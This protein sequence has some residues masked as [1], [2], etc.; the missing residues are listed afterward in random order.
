MKQK[1]P[2]SFQQVSMLSFNY[3]ILLGC[4]TTTPLIFYAFI[5]EKLF[6]I[7][8]Y[9]IWSIICSYSLH[10]AWNWVSIKCK[11]G[12]IRVI[13]SV[14][15][16]IKWVQVTLVKSST[17]VRNTVWPVYV[18]VFVGTP[19]IYMEQLES[20]ANVDLMVLIGKDFLGCF[21][22]GHIWQICFAKHPWT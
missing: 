4:A 16:F 1:R 8:F 13:E 9:K 14:L 5:K 6:H 19:N 3:P 11:K 17:M 15:F 18:Y 2:T 12:I 7:S 21:A 22:M 10:W 20:N